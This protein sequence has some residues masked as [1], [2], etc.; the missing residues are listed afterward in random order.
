[1][2]KE[3]NAP[4]LFSIALVSLKSPPTDDALLIDFGGRL[5][6]YA[7]SGRRMEAV[8]GC[9]DL[10]LPIELCGLSGA[11]NAP[12]IPGREEAIDGARR[13]LLPLG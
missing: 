13:E 3:E 6:S 9:R 11:S 8:D 5:R 4:G 10:L 2:K 12:P 1:M 7:L